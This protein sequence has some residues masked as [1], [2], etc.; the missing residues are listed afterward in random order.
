MTTD[1]RLAAHGIDIE[2]AKII[3]PSAA[4]EVLLLTAKSW[5]A[6][7][8]VGHPCRCKSYIDLI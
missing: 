2:E 8:K 6:M 7:S 3:A 5:Y 1:D 4:T